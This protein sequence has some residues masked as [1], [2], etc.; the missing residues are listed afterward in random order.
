MGAGAAAAGGPVGAKEARSAL[1]A[2][3]P[4]GRARSKSGPRERREEGRKEGG[5]AQESIEGGARRGRALRAP[6]KAWPGPPAPP[7]TRSCPEEEEEGEGA[8]SSFPRPPARPCPEEPPGQRRRGVARRLTPLPARR[9]A[10]GSLGSFPAA[11]WPTQSGVPPEPAA[12]SGAAEWQARD[13]VLEPVGPFQQHRRH[14]LGLLPHVTTRPPSLQCR[15]PSA[16]GALH[17]KGE[18][19]EGPAIGQEGPRK[20]TGPLV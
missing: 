18:A 16:R 2:C 8:N 11:S 20:K 15:H 12:S 14:E 6:G 10:R 5:G 3:L 1:P 7:R 13:G 19:W 4:R 9:P 17:P